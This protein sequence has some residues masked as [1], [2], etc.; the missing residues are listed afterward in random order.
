MT[1]RHS[2]DAAL[3]R[4]R[5]EK[6]LAGRRDLLLHSLVYVGIAILVALNVGWHEPRG[7][8]AALGFWTIP[9][10]LHGLRYYYCCGPGVFMR[11]DEIE[12]AIAWQAGRGSLDEDEELL[13]EERAAKRVLARRIVVAHGL[14]SALFMLAY[15]VS[16]TAEKS[17]YFDVAR[18]LQEIGG[19]LSLAFALHLLRFFFAHGRTPQGRALKI[20]AAIERAWTISR[21]SQR[22]RRERHE[23]QAALDLGESHGIRMRLTDD[24]EFADD[25]AS[26]SAESR[27]GAAGWGG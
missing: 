12:G 8:L 24:G 11:A 6:R 17:Q 23:D 16:M 9:L 14:A 27:T 1:A 20:D 18:H 5:V 19:W 26:G 22:A 3:M 10:A 2:L 7:N 21:E 25:E 4:Y 13:I 15:T